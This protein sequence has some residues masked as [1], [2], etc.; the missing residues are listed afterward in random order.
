MLFGLKKHFLD[1]SEPDQRESLG[2]L[3]AFLHNHLY[4][5]LTEAYQHLAETPQQVWDRAIA[6][7]NI[8]RQQAALDRA[9]ED[10]SPVRFRR[11]PRSTAP[12]HLIS[13]RPAK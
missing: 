1:L 9:I 5:D 6:H 11:L 3:L 12:M 7:G 10:G 2:A 13:S 8:C 4:A